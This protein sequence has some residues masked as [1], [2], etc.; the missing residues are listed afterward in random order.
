[1]FHK[2]PFDLKLPEGMAVAIPDAVQKLAAGNVAQTQ[3]AYTQFL[4]LAAQAQELMTQAQT[5]LSQSIGTPANASS[6]TSTDTSQQAKDAGAVQAKAQRY[7]S[8][9]IDATFR[10][11]G[12][13]AQARDMQEYAEIQT[14]YAQTQV[15]TF[16][17]QARDLKRLVED[18]A[19]KAARKQP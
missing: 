15:I 6:Q 8:Q 5:S 1:M 18:L 12:D 16:D 13:L 19:K 3:A 17:Q 7:A 11:A 2:P 9:N 10:L 4:S 14:R